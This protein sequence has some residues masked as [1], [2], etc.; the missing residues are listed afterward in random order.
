MATTR[1]PAAPTSNGAAPRAVVVCHIDEGDRH[2]EVTLKPIAY[3]EM[4][5]RYGDKLP[6]EAVMFGA[7]VQ[8]GRPGFDFE[9][10]VAGLDYFRDE[11]VTDPQ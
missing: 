7:W 4:G 8:L 10:W 1:K 11:L 5:R 3:L 6:N 2:H 9:T